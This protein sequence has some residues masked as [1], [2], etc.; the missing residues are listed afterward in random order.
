M[1]IWIN[2]CLQT[3]QVAISLFVSTRNLTVQ[4][5]SASNYEKIMLMSQLIC[6]C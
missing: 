3:M 1:M 6:Y 5:L 2:D 4:I